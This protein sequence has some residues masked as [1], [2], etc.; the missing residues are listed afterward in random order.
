MERQRGYYE[1]S[2]EQRRRRQSES[3][4][5][6]QVQIQKCSQFNHWPLTSKKLDIV[7]VIL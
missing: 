5:K 4:A 7:T 2:K 1:R 6:N 3:Y